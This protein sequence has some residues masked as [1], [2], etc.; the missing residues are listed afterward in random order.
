MVAE[1]IPVIVSITQGSDGD[2]EGLP[3]RVQRVLYHFCLMA[4]GESVR[5]KHE[6]PFSQ[7][8]VQTN[9]WLKGLVTFFLIYTWVFFIQGTFPVNF[10]RKDKQ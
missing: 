5:H 9:V 1:D 8:H 4:N 2:L 7:T 3:Y 10:Q 6:Q